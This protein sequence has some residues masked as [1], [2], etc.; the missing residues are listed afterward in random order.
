MASSETLQR[1]TGLLGH[2]SLTLAERGDAVALT[3][4][5]A[6]RLFAA[7]NPATDAGKKE[8]P[9]GIRNKFTE[10]YVDEVVNPAVLRCVVANNLA[11]IV[12]ESDSALDW[13]VEMYLKFRKL[14][15]QSLADGSGHRPR[16]TM[17][18]LA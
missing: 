2:D 18:T 14:A 17:R 6:F 8:L 16:Y 9:A 12:P 11:T 7:M 4:H 13:T 15:E 10:L 5:P 1:L 3:R